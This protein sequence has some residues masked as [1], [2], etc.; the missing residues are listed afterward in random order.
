MLKSYAFDVDSNLLF[1]DTKIIMEK[2]WND[3]IWLPE[4]VSQ[5]QY[6]IIKSDKENYRY[7]D[8]N[9]EK[10]MANFRW[11]GNFEEVI[12]DALNKNQQWPSWDKFIEANRYASPIAIITAR[13]HPVE[14]FKDTH[15]KLII[16][17]FNSWQQEDLL[18]SMKERLWDYKQSDEFYIEKYLDNNYYAPCS[19]EVFL[20]SIGKTLSD[21]MPD[22]KNAAFE[23]FVLH[24]KKIFE[25]YYWANF[26]ANR[27]IRIGFSDDTSSIIEWIHHHIHTMDIGLM[28]KH[29]E[30]LFRMYNTGGDTRVAPIKYSYKNTEE[31]K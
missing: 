15:K 28:R 16:D 19:D 7:I 12:F 9:I 10:T 17:N 8:N 2:K 23:K 31:E 24:T 1:T 18:N 6:E 26:M 25:T 20:A 22:R 4:E 13:G 29:P 14:D 30:I 11:A 21:K 3:G 5:Q 27:K